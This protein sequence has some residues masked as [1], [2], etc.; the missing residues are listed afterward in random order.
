MSAFEHNTNNATNNVFP[1]PIALSLVTLPF[2]GSLLF[3]EKLAK[4]SIELGKISEEVFRGDRLPILTFPD[5][6][7]SPNP[8]HPLKHD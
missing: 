1:L 7:Y 3:A 4:G 6:S 5:H 8:D 2:L